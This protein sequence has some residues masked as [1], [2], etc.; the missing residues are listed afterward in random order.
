[1]INIGI[2]AHADAGKTTLTERMLFERGR[3]GGR[4]AWTTA[5][6][7]PTGWKSSGIGDFRALGQAGLVWRGVRVNILDTPAIWIL[8]GKWSGPLRR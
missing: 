3:S 4:G 6:P 7:R 8:R 1:M 2:L 5:R